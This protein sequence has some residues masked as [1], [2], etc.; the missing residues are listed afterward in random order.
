MSPLRAPTIRSVPDIVLAKLDCV[1]RFEPD[2]RPTAVP[3]LTAID[4]TVRIAVDA[5]DSCRLR[6]TSDNVLEMLCSIA[7]EPYRSVGLLEIDRNIKMR[8]KRRIVT[9]ENDRAVRPVGTRT[10]AG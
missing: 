9:D 10:A 2:R 3:A 1:H 8:R 5:C 6:K 4:A 7:T